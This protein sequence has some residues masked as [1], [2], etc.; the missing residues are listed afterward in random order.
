MQKINFSITDEVVS[1]GVKVLTVQISGVKNTTSIPEFNEYLQKELD[2]RKNSWQNKNYKEDSILQ[3]FQDLHSKVDR[4][5]RD[6]P[7]SPE[8]LLKLFLERDRFPRINTIVDIYNLI[9]L[10][11][12]LALGAHDVSKIKGNVTLR[13]IKGDESFV[14]LGKQEVTQVPAG[15]YSYVDDE[16]NIICRMEVL[17]VE[18]T[19]ITLDT[20]DIFLIVQ[21][22]AKTENVY[23]EN[24]ANEVVELIKKFCGGESVFLNH[25]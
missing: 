13:L 12:Q 5:N 10:K 4:S 18:P 19:K 23:I 1:L 24:A 14:P 2:Q 9:S 8:V 7:A 20:K 3:G 25:L 11:T 17:Q 16:N 15:E 21:G 22:N 6:Y